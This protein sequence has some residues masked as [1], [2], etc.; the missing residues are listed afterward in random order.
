M[1]FCAGRTE[2]SKLTTNLNPSLLTISIFRTIHSPAIYA[3][4]HLH[5]MLINKWCIPYDA[6]LG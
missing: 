3:Q 1:I 6:R 5:L 4:I 2:V